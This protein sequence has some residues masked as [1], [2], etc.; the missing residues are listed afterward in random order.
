MDILKQ[1]IGFQLEQV[2]AMD[3]QEALME[4]VTQL[5]TLM[6]TNKHS[7]KQ[8]TKLKV[9]TNHLLKLEHTQM[10]VFLERLYQMAELLT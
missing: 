7:L 9:T 1:V 10:L 3:L 2:Q 5:A 6:L 4:T 8:L